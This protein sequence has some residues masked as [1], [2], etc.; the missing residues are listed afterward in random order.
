MTTGDYDRWAEEGPEMP[1]DSWE[2]EEAPADQKY[3]LG[4]VAGFVAAIVGGVLWAVLVYITDME[5][6]YAALGVGALVGL[7]AM[8]ATG[9]GDKTV[10]LMS[11]ALGMFGDDE[12]RQI[13][14]PLVNGHVVDLSLEDKLD[15]TIIDLVFLIFTMGA[16]WQTGS[17][18]MRGTT[19]YSPMYGA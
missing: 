9:E 16:A 4:A 7:A 5:L 17:D 3:V 15:L 12:R 6:G 2:Q 18:R 11:G 13:V 14:A 19:G 8:L 10:G 1:D